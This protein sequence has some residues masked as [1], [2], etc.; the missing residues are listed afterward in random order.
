MK[1]LN[2]TGLHIY[3]FGEMNIHF[4]LV[5]DIRDS[6]TLHINLYIRAV[7]KRQTSFARHMYL[8]IDLC[9][10]III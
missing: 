2:E 10:L 6:T 9:Y 5:I 7:I 1:H 3:S 8:S 4:Y